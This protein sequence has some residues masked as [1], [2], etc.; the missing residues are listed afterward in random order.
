MSAVE[1]TRRHVEAVVFDFGETLID[2]TRE[3]SARADWA[4]VPRLTFLAVLGGLIAQGRPFQEVFD[5]LGVPRPGDGS[6]AGRL[7]LPP[8]LRAD[9]LYPD[10][11]PCLVE[12][13]RL[14]LR[15][16]DSRESAGSCR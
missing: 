13:R 2:E 10:A 5:V 3:W 11:R 16:G 12:L 14:G 8:G 6:D 1:S 4:G 15:V 7:P 9:D